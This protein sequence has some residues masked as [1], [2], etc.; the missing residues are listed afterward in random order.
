[1]VVLCPAKRS[2]KSADLMV[3]LD[4]VMLSAIFQYLQADCESCAP[5]RHTKSLGS[6]SAAQKS[7]ED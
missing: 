2:V 6:F 5:S 4:E 3:Q 1:M 7:K